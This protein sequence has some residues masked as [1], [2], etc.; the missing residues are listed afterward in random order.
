MYVLISSI[1][2]PTSYIIS[3][4]PFSLTNSSTNFKQENISINS[5]QSTFIVVDL[6]ARISSAW[7]DRPKVVEWVLNFETFEQFAGETAFEVTLSFSNIFCQ[8]FVTHYLTY[9]R[10]ACESIHSCTC[11]VI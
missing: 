5:S 6:S 1:A 9:F 7:S 8:H 2:T 4:S 10:E 3:T 11:D